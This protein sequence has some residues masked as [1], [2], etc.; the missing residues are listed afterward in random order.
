MLT[1]YIIQLKHKKNLHTPNTGHGTVNAKTA[2][3]KIHKL[4]LCISV[5]EM[6]LPVTMNKAPDGDMEAKNTKQ[7]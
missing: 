4:L 2:T 1:N 7:F 5:V 3:K 6:L